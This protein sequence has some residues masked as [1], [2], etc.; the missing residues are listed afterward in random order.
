MVPVREAAGEPVFQVVIGS[1]ANPGLRDFA[2]VAE[3]VKGRQAHDQVSFDV[4]PASRQT[5]A[6]LAGNGWLS[7][8]IAAGARIHQSGCL[9]CIGMGQ[10]P[11]SGRN[12]L[13]TVPR[14]FPGRSGAEEDS[15]WLCSPE[16]AAA[17]A[18]TGVITDPRDLDADY[19]RLELPRQTQV[20]TAMLVA[21]VPADDARG[22]ELV[23]GP[24]IASL[25]EFDPL[26]D[27]RAFGAGTA[28]S[29]PVAGRALDRL[30]QRRLLPLLAIGF[31]A[32][33]TALAVASGHSGPGVLDAVAAAAGLTR[34]PVEAAL[35]A[36]WPK[37]VPPNRVAAYAL[38]STV[39]ELIWIGGPLLLALLLATAA[40]SS[41]CS[42]ALPRA[43]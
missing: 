1:S 17:A 20:N 3:I 16:T 13:R 6:D 28:V 36:M 39:Q 37:L 10:A 25:P 11:A 7:D 34:P 22:Q 19:P 23:K 32:A 12:S 30:G 9:G 4:N 24:N 8:L 2:I 31:A 5:L 15:V 33:L 38:D 41:R 18:L 14:N 26:P 35:R 40:A 27:H 29:A 21:P 42:L 43:P